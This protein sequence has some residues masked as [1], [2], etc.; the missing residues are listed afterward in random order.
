MHLVW[1]NDTIISNKIEANLS[2][3]R[4]FFG[5]GQSFNTYVFFCTLSV[6]YMS[7]PYI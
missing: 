5:M 2:L 6:D 7:I 4:P 1:H 3:F